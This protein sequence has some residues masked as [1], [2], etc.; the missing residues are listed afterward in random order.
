MANLNQINTAISRLA[1]AERITKALLSG[2][3][4]DLIQYVLLGE[5]D[6][7]PSYDIDAV[8]RCM[9]ACTPM[10]RRTAALFFNHFMPFNY[11]EE[12]QR[13]GKME[14]KQKAKKEQLCREFMDNP[15]ND[16]WSWSAD[17]VKMEQKEPDYLGKLTKDI[18]KAIEAGVDT[19][20]IVNAVVAGGLSLNDIIAVLES[21]D[22]Q[23]EAA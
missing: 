16:I 18:T 23:Q 20:S 2:L 8:N 22:E 13:F 5:D 11:I 6:V 21:M 3:S 17:N 1:K 12:E 9:N 10:N 15:D 14:K 19:P 7:E 4:R